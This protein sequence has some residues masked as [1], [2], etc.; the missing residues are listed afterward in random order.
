[1]VAGQPTF[2]AWLDLFEYLAK[3]TLAF[4]YNST[5]FDGPGVELQAKRYGRDIRFHDT[6]DLRQRYI[7]IV[8]SSGNGRKGRLADVI[9][10][11]GIRIDPR[12]HRARADVIATAHITETLLE[13]HGI[14]GVLAKTLHALPL[15]T[16]NVN[17]IKPVLDT[18]MQEVLEEIH[19][20]GYDK[21]RIARDLGI[22]INKVA[23]T[24]W[25]L[26]YGGN[27]RIEEIE[28]HDIQEWIKPRIKECADKAWTNE[29]TH[30]R[31]KP[32]LQ[33][34]LALPQAPHID[35]T[36]LKVGLTRAGLR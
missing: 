20:K 5:S 19:Q 7:D 10:V 32:V 15:P 22:T 25:D 35:Y 33:M 2:A 34:I 31:L 13:H 23:D 1:M 30:G 29:E 21:R 16:Q 18:L 14:T 17:H 28:E 11:L 8:R 9:Q 4:G 27:L 12:F 36:Q 6:L 3:D 24:A 26:F